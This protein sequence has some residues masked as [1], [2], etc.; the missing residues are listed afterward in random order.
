[1]NIDFKKNIN[2]F[3]ESFFRLVNFNKAE[4][5][6]FRDLLKKHIIDEKDKLDLATVEFVDTEKINLVFLISE[7]DDGI[8]TIDQKLF[9]CALTIDSYHEMLRLIQPF[10]EKETKA[11]ATLYDVDTPIDLLFSPSAT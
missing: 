6:L 7:E 1:M 4:S 3:G 8:I 5:I 9:F 11:F 2:D 10:C